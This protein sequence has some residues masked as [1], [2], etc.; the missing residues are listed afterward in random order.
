MAFT[1]RKGNE[2]LPG[3]AGYEAVTGGG[4]WVLFLKLFR[5]MLSVVWGERTAI[6]GKVKLNYLVLVEYFFSI[7]IPEKIT[8]IG[9]CAVLPLA[10]H[11]TISILLH[12]RF[13][14]D[15]GIFQWH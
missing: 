2:T 3:G 7:C 4:I 12:M 10:Y 11:N 14:L 13:I 1:R 6:L 9:E 5:C 15:T 8:P